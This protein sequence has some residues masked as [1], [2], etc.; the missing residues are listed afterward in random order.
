MNLPTNV[1]DFFGDFGLDFWNTDKIWSPAV[2][3]AENNDNYEVTAELPGMKKDE[4]KISYEDDVLT[5]SGERKTEKDEKDKN[6]RRVERCFGKFQRSF[7][8][9]KNVK[10]DEIKAKYKNG[11]L[12]VNI[13][14]AEETKSKEIAIS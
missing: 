4:I 9:P 2:D 7:Y 13:P 11:V 8:L 5:L 14:K 3:I 12:T 1:N 10:A 6:F